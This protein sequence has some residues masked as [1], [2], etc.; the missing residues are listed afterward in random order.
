MKYDTVSSGINS[1]KESFNCLVEVAAAEARRISRAI[2]KVAGTTAC[3]GVQVNGLKKW[4]IQNGYW[5]ERDD[6]LGEF[7]DRGSE[8]EVYMDYDNQTVNKLNDFRYADDNLDSFFQ[9]IKIHND[10]FADC[11]YTSL[12]PNWKKSQ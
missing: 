4:A 6:S 1:E 8:N 9:R 10:L 7:S 3:K 5:F 2:Q 12:S 11:A